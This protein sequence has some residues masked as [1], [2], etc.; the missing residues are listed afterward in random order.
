MNV[1][2]RIE[3]KE[4]DRIA[5]IAPHPDDEC[6]GASAAL[7]LAPQKTDIFV[8][9]DGSRGALERTPEEETLIRRAQFEAEMEYVKPHSYT[10]LGGEDTRMS[11]H[12]DIVSKIDFKPYTIVFL[13]WLKSF[14]PDHRYA[15]AFCL[16]EI[17]SQKSETACYFY[18][19]KAPFYDPTH[20]IDITGIY[21]EKRK[22]IRFHE[23]QAEQEDLVLSLNAFRAAQ[24]ISCPDLL[25]VEAYLK[26]DPDKVF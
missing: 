11:W 13:P 18:E 24:M 2:K 5:V 20:Y 3:F 14:H 15:S 7:I 25:Y 16:N 21:E 26:A 19:I 22:L 17:L 12:R 4:E 1:R 6:L 23:D 9:T 10:W 8:L